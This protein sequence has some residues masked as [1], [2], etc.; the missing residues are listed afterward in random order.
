LLFQGLGHPQSCPHLLKGAESAAK[1][2]AQVEASQAR[3]K[4]KA[5]KAEKRMK[6]EME[7]TRQV[8]M[9]EDRDVVKEELQSEPSTNS[10]SEEESKEVE[11]EY[12]DVSVFVIEPLGATATGTSRG[13]GV[14]S[15]AP[16]AR[17]HAAEGDAVQEEEAKRARVEQRS[18]AADTEK[19]EGGSEERA[20]SGDI[21]RWRARPTRPVVRRRPYRAP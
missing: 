11:S 14:S 7:I 1:Q 19:R 3:K 21:R 8:R 16:E 20:R 9:G 4:K 17:K 12:E 10:D 15:N 13:P 6:K 2:A 18:E 5:E